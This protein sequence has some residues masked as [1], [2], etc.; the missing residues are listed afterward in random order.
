M[1]H[2]RYLDAGQH[3]MDLTY[4]FYSPP[5]FRSISRTKTRCSFQTVAN[6]GHVTA[7]HFLVKYIGAPLGIL[8][9]L[10]LVIYLLSWCFSS[11][12]LHFDAEAAAVPV[13]ICGEFHLLLVGNF[14]TLLVTITQN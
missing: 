11:F 5:S 14:A 9:S 10:P 7:R 4:L 2:Y 8:V 13:E 1:V 6:H 3:W 12:G